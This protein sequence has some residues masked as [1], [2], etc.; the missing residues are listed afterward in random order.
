MTAPVPRVR[1]RDIT[2]DDVEAVDAWQ[3]DP[4]ETGEFN[5]FGIASSTIRPGVEERRMVGR[6]G[7]MLLVERI[8]DRRPI[9]TVSWRAVPYGPND[10][11]R[12]WNIGISLVSGA[13]G[14]GLGAEAQRLLASHLF[15]TTDA[16]RVEASTDI[17]NVA[18]QRALA[19]AG[20]AREGV[21]RGAQWRAGSHHDLVIFA[22]LRED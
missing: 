12:A 10:R 14:Q 4:L 20:F 13:R 7:G 22:R 6:G 19:R 8:A 9:G 18:E 1:L 3:A 15:A 21:N 11:S 5:D 2:L 16:N 17:E